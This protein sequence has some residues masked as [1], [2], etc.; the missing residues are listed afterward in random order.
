MLTR[1]ARRRNTQ[2]AS[3]KRE[4]L[5]H[6]ESALGPRAA[7]T[8]GHE[9]LDSAYL[10]T[11]SSYRIY[12]AEEPHVGIGWHQNYRTRRKRGGRVL[13]QAPGGFR[14][15]DHQGRTAA[16]WQPDPRHGADRQGEEG[17]AGKR[18]L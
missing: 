14:R 4:P 10:L 18:R 3:L 6:A 12:D 5:A 1:R 2:S 11:A 15:G 8:W 9:P 17:R 13:R 16:D 7:R